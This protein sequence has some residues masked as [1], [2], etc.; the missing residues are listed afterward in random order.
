MV[1]AAGSIFT[2]LVVDVRGGLDENDDIVT[3]TT[4]IVE[5]PIK[6][7]FAT[8]IT[9]KQF[10]GEANGLS[11]YLSHMRYFQSGERVL[12]ML[13]PESDMGFTSPIAMNQ[14]VWDISDGKVLRV[15]NTA[16][17]G[18]DARLAAHNITRDSN[19]S[20]DK[21]AFITLIAEMVR[22]GSAR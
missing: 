15:S 20:I 19:G 4:F 21:E 8:W 14:G 5:R 17:A 22:E 9:I 3:Y 12:L 6:G 18:M 10:G 13:H 2:G 11:T 1:E 7:S 16:L